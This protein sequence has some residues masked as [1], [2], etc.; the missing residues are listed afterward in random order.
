MTVFLTFVGACFIMWGLSLGFTFL[1]L[2][3][4]AETHMREVAKR[5]W[6]SSWDVFNPENYRESGQP[7]RRA[8]VKY[9]KYQ[10]A[11]TGIGAALVIF[12][13]SL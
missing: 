9:A 4:E 7:I 2:A 8:A 5:G 3:H 13:Q 1:I 10:M 6:S 11:V 12:G